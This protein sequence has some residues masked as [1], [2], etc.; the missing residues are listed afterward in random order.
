VEELKAKRAAI[1][2][3]AEASE[4]SGFFGILCICSKTSYMLS[5]EMVDIS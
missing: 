4:I 2:A 3:E 5:I 1:Q